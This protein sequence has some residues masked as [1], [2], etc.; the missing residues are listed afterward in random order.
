[1]DAAS[2]RRSQLSEAH[3]EETGQTVQHRTRDF[4]NR[5][6]DPF[7]LGSAAE[8]WLMME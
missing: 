4:G 3:A 8:T 1:M 5:E 6:V 7:T 2:R